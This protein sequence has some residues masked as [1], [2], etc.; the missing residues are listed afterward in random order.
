M[1]RGLVAHAGR[2]L[3]PDGGA[4]RRARGLRRGLGAQPGRARS[5]RRRSGRSAACCSRLGHRG[6]RLRSRA[7]AS[8]SSFR[9]IDALLAADA[10]ADRRDA[11]ASGPIVGRA[12]PRPARRRAHARADRATCAGCGLRLEEEGPPPGEG[13]L[14]GKTLVL[15]GT[16]PDLTREEA[17]ERIVAAGGRVTSSVSKKT[18]Y[19]VAGDEP[20]LQAREGRAARRRGARRGRAARAARA[21]R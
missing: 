13:P 9:S 1:E 20:G 10:G 18:D 19:V 15:T 21:R 16:L 6:R 4:A 3:P 12:D 7:A 14:A 17:T 8:R 11:R 5:R 2:L